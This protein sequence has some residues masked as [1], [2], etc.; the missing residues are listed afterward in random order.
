MSPRSLSVLTGFLKLAA[1]IG[2]IAGCAVG[3]ELPPWALGPFTR[4]DGAQPLIRPNADSRFDCPVRKQSIP[5]EARHTFNPAATVMNGRICML[6]RAEDNTGNGSIGSYTS[7]LGLA[8]SEDGTNFKRFPEPVIF[9]AKDNQWFFEWSGGCEDPRLAMGP[10]GTYVL[11]YTQYPGRN[12]SSNFRGGFR[13]GLATSKDL[14]TWTKH[15]SPFAGTPFE[16]HRI[17]SA[18]ILQKVENGALVA[19]KAN[20]KYWMYF[21]EQAVYLASSDNLI[22]WE[23]L[24]NEQG[25]FLEIMNT[26]KGKFD[27]LLTEVGPSPTLTDSGIVLIYNGKN[28]DPNKN[29]SPSLANGVYTCGQALFDKTDPSKLVTRLDEPFFKP[30]LDWEKS[31]QY[32]AGTTFAEG[33][34]RFKGR[35]F[36][37]Y[38]C[39]DTFVGVAFTKD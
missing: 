13:I 36:L 11:T 7:R 19:A 3:A 5:W 27:S 26:R 10:D 12:P 23:P 15:G 1:S 8:V 38:G 14:R 2:T 4:P 16:L 25:D 24:A 9:P 29:G 31:G 18:G 33:L 22:Q 30:E 34:A 20:G 21:G 35:W 39:A 17:K 37:S 28:G 6:Y 32:A